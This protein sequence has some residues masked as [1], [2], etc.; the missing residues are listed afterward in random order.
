VRRKI[1]FSKSGSCLFIET[2]IQQELETHAMQIQW[3]VKETARKINE[4]TKKIELKLLDKIDM[5]RQKSDISINFT[6]EKTSQENY[7]IIKILKHFI[8]ND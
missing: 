1:K 8:N 4:S 6:I 7:E 2:Y 3:L 5:R